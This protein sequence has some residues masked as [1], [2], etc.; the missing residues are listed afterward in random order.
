MSEPVESRERRRHALRLGAVVIGMFG[1]GYALVPF[2]NAL[3]NSIGLNGAATRSSMLIS[4]AQAAATKVDASRTVTVQFV[5]TVN[6]GR[7]W[8]FRPEVSSLKVHPGELAKA[9]FFAQTAEDHDVVAQA[10][11]RVAPVE[12]AKYLRKT[13]CFCF[14]QQTLKP[15]VGQEMEVRFLL[16]PA[17]PPDVDNVVLS[18]TF[19]DVTELAQKA[20]AKPQS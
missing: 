6:A 13:D 3:C 15:N 1:F 18:Y 12:A 16:D 10:V 20:G 2:Y 14:R 5:T 4:P 8:V 9:V 17:L 7:A 11:P 19:F